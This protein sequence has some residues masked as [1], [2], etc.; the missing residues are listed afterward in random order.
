M[1][2]SYDDWRERSFSRSDIS[3]GLVHLTKSKE[4]DGGTLSPVDVLIKI[5]ND[6]KIV[7]SNPGSAYIHGSTCAVCFQDTPIY[8]IAQNVAFEEEHHAS[9][10]RYSGCGLIF[11]KVNI[12]KRGGRPVIY[13]TP[14]KAKKI[15]ADV[16]EHWRIV[17]LDLSDTSDIVD[18][19]HEREWRLP[20][21][22]EF[23][24]GEA[25]ILLN[26]KDCYR[27]FM[28]K[29]QGSYETLKE[30]CGIIVLTGL[31]I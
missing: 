10:N 7:G 12:F 1:A 5:L 15:L 11:S 30:L 19:T 9:K 29:M 17:R 21:D 31:L 6:R 20:G 13:E 16:S 28:D 4:I 26:D 22:L 27:E 8:G 23:R 2:Y 18:W 24:Y 3:T 14:E 25:A